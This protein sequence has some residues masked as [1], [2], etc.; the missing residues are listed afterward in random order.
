M[1][2]PVYLISLC[3]KIIAKESKYLVYFHFKGVYLGQK[4][5]SII[6][7]SKI[8]LEIRQEYYVLFEAQYVKERTLFGRLLKF[9]SID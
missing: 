5:E 6:L 9:R 7:E 8:E 4:I 1:K 2:K 3:E